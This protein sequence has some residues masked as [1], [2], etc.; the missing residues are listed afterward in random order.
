M[1]AGRLKHK[2]AI[3]RRLESD[4]TT[5]QVEE[6]Y[7]D[8]INVRAAIDPI[9]GR[10]FFA[11]AQVQAEITTK[12]T[13][14]YRAG[15]HETM[16]VVHTRQYGS[17]TLVDVYDIAAPPIDRESRHEWLELMCVKRS[18]EGFRSEGSPDGP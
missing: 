5:G 17:P 7:E 9:S 15:V 11:A 13:I 3:Q 1:H 14:R 12:I 10:E 16:R 8:W 4:G 2:V 18:A 6:R